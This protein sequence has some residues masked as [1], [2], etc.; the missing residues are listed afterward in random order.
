MG[1]KIKL[2][3]FPQPSHDPRTNI[4]KFLLYRVTTRRTAIYD[5]SAIP[6]LQSQLL[7]GGDIIMNV[8]TSAN[9]NSEIGTAR[10]HQPDEPLPPQELQTENLMTTRKVHNFQSEEG[11]ISI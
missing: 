5:L 3:V 6:P 9:A 8:T 1:L 2:V 7:A 4:V 11:C 10:N